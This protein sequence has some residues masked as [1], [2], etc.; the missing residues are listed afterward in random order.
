MNNALRALLCAMAAIA[1]AF[2]PDNSTALRSAL[3]ECTTT[4]VHSDGS[5]IRD[6][7]VSRITDMNEA[8][9]GLSGFNANISNW[10]TSGVTNFR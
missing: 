2:A 10:N 4:C 8:L 3:R 6:W 7:D 1:A 9:R 5:H